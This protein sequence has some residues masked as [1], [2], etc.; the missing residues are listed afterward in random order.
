MI[1]YAIV[2]LSLSFSLITYRGTVVNS[3]LSFM[4]LAACRLECKLAMDFRES[5]CGS[6]YRGLISLSPTCQVCRN[7]SVY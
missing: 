5:G 4:R 3:N 1:V 2:M 7:L 6:G